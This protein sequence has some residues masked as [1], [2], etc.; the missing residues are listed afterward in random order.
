VIELIFADSADSADE[1]LGLVAEGKAD[2]AAYDSL[3]IATQVQDHPQLRITAALTESQYLAFA[4][5]KGSPLT[6]KLDAHIQ[7]LQE[8]GDFQSYL[9]KHFSD[10]VAELNAGD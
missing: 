9:Q 4:L 5:A 2:A 8:S 10:E 6:A 7:K 1:L 3:K